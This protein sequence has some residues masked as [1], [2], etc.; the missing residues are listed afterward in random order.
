MRESIFSII[1]LAHAI[2]SG[3]QSAPSPKI[4]SVSEFEKSS[5]FYAAIVNNA[6]E[7]KRSNETIYSS[8]ENYRFLDF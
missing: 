3:V 8:N 5:K 1:L 2:N 6:F 4:D 7:S